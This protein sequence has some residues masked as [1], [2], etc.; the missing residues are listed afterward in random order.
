MDF[1]SAQDIA[2]RNTVR[3]IGLFSLAVLSMVILTNLV[4]MLCL[5]LLSPGRGE[6]LQIDWTIFGAVSCGVVS[7]IGLGSLYKTRLLAGGGDKIA[8]QMNG[9]IVFDD[10]TDLAEKRLHN[11][12]EEM[13]IAS[14]VPVP[15]VYIIPGSG[16]NAFA[17]GHSYSDAVIGV[18]R[19]ALEQLT[20]DE[21]Q[22]VIAHEFSHILNG[23]MRLNIRL[24]GVLHGI[25]L[26]GLIGSHLLRFT[27]RSRN[28]KGSGGFFVLGLGLVGIGYSGTFF[29][30]LIK[31]A[32]NRQREY[33]AD[34]AA[35]QFTRNPDGIAGALLRIGSSKAGSTLKQP[36]IAEISHAL[37]SQGVDSLFATHPPLAQ[38][39]KRL[40]PAWDGHFTPLVPGPVLQKEHEP[41]AS[42]K[43][44]GSGKKEVGMMAA[45][46]AILE[47][48]KAL[49]QVGRPDKSHLTQ[50]RQFIDRLPK[51]L[52]DA[53]HSPYGAK[54]TIY[55]LVLDRD[56]EVCNRQLAYLDGILDEGAC[57]EVKRLKTVLS[58]L[59][60]EHRLPLVD[61]AL[62][63]LRQLSTSQY[64]KFK[65]ILEAL[66][67]ADRRITFFE[68]ILQKVVIHHLDGIFSNTTEK[69]AREPHIRRAG[70]AGALLLAV[71][72]QNMQEQEGGISRVE[73]QARILNEIRWIEVA[74]VQQVQKI[75][76]KDLDAALNDL[77]GLRP[78]LKKSL[79]SGCAAIV[80]ADN[81]VSTQETE[82]LRAVASSLNCPMPILGN[83]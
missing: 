38:R 16:I 10:S 8:L 78:Q 5:G 55:A 77:A 71:F 60:T 48:Q 22:G 2:R 54:S 28:S 17:A 20:R 47:G 23:D 66:I 61:L 24:V 27:P 67:A 72:L 15:S 57:T 81:H 11:I 75:S 52:K 65:E 32:V 39:I 82:L 49:N 83:K 18:S 46:A 53:V 58:T 19:G 34:S 29:G 64:T 6:Q 7:I 13:A 21:M 50:A 70:E 59:E 43:K 35:V 45:G 33:L 30:N 76:V 31:A 26:I 51:T 9:E 74:D 37:F 36:D 73:M 3:L 40:L 62:P 68:W 69:S 14:G 12:V 1:F 42:G 63:A 44:A 56:P 80:M 79:L 41:Q 4:V 25:L